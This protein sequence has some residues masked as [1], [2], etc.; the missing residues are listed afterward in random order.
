M[1]KTIKNEG[2]TEQKKLGTNRENGATNNAEKEE[3]TNNAEAKNSELA[4]LREVVEAQQKQLNKLSKKEVSYSKVDKNGF[5]I[6][7]EHS[8]DALSNLTPLDKYF[9]K[10]KRYNSG[11][12]E[13]AIDRTDKVDYIFY[14]QKQKKYTFWK[15]LPLTHE[16]LKTLDKKY[17]KILCG[18]K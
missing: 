9:N 7:P 18:K 10:V 14:H 2:N 8:K 15:G 12:K 5:P 16:Q 13:N 1:A 4:D 6:K 3:N 11:T 17:V